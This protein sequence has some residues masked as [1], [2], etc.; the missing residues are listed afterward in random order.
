MHSEYPDAC[1]VNE[2]QTSWELISKHTVIYP[3]WYVCFSV[4]ALQSDKK[5]K[6][7]TTMDKR[8]LFQSLKALLMDNLKAT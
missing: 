2:F 6:K 3:A 8:S 5:R 4:E 7:E 1:S